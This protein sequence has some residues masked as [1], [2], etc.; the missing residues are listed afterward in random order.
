LILGSPK[1]K[2]IQK[3]RPGFRPNVETLEDRVVPTLTV[4]PAVYSVMHDQ[5]LASTSD[6]SNG[7]YGVLQNDTTDTTHAVAIS[8]VNSGSFD[9]PITLPS[10]AVLDI[11]PDGGF[12]YWAHAGFSGDD[13]FTIT[14]SDTVE[15]TTTTVTIHVLP[16]IAVSSV[17]V[18]GGAPA[19]I[20]CNGLSVNLEG[21][22]SVIEQLQVTF[23]QPVSLDANAFTVTNVAE[24]VTVLAGPNPSTFPVTAIQT[25]V[26]GSGG[27]QWIVTFSGEGTDA[28]NTT[29]GG[30]GTVIKDGLYILTTVGSRVHADGVTAA[31]NNVVFWALNGSDYAPD[32]TPTEVVVDAPDFNLFKN[33]FGAESDLPGDSGQP[34]Y[35]AALDFNLD[36]VVD[37]T[38][39]NIFK[40]NFGADWT[41]NGVVAAD[42]TLNAIHDRDLTID[43]NQCAVDLNGDPMSF[44]VG[45]PT[46]GAIT[47]NTDGTYTY[48][49]PTGWT[50]TDSFTFAASDSSAESNTAI[51][52]INVTNTAPQLDDE[53]YYCA[54]NQTDTSLDLTETATD[55]EYDTLT[56]AVVSYPT[57][58]TLA[59][60]TDGTYNYTP[61]TNWLGTDTFTVKAN[62]GLADS[63]TATISIVTDHLLPVADANSYDITSS[64]PTV[65]TLAGTND[66]NSTLSYLVTALPT[67]GLLYDGPD[68]TGHQISSADLDAGD[69]AVT[70]SLHRVYF[71]P[72]AHDY[73][74]DSVYFAV[75]DAM[76]QSDEAQISLNVVPP[77]NAPSVSGDLALN[78]Y[79]G[80]KVIGLDLASHVSF[81]SG[82]SD[83]ITTEQPVFGS[84]SFNSTTG[85]YDYTADPNYTGKVSFTFEAND[86][87]NSTLGEATFFCQAPGVVPLSAFW[88]EAI[89]GQIVHFRNR[90]TQNFSYQR[91]VG[92]SLDAPTIHEIETSARNSGEFVLVRCPC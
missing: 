90:R 36:G 28:I 54:L 66:G 52:T 85:K 62:D 45:T 67:R 55:A 4:V 60:N 46:Y 86:G 13:T 38:D 78:V 17:V 73:G 9:T 33:T 51:V 50:G 43:L 41:W 19:Y 34:A 27:T 6:G 82:G 14:V 61:N 7:V 35:V 74:E 56:V 39:Y 68:S 53:T 40:A 2:P 77:S 12:T 81:P 84:L 63:N 88:N 18:N 72:D 87:T 79:T 26:A 37:A 32:N 42:T 69:Y 64:A 71:V 59:L 22:N 11:K 70:D 29:N 83:T 24:A 10:L 8:Q 58:G 5:I 44:A 75:T 49:P 47:T 91:N 16:T 20:D 89:N 31:D 30:T 65:I 25:P 21:Q 1:S 57:H 48:T 80:G 23:N 3:S 92:T 76:G 15:T